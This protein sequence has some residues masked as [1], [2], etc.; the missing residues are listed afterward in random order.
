VRVE[1]QAYY[2][3]YHESKNV[4][5]NVSPADYASTVI[6]YVTNYPYEYHTVSITAYILQIVIVMLMGGMVNR[7]QR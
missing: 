1:Q 6:L 5:A 4:H 2:Y 3:T 7:R